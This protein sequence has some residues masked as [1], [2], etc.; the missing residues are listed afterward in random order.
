MT[1][2]TLLAVA[3]FALR[4]AVA[5]PPDPQQLKDE[6]PLA[7]SGPHRVYYLYNNCP[8]NINLIESGVFSGEVI[9]SRNFTTRSTTSDGWRGPFYT[10]ANGGNVDGSGS[11][12]AL[13][14]NNVWPH[15]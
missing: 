3:T 9:P 10:D 1:F 14:W 15:F 11:A 4:L 13:F 8:A 6:Q 2:R 7:A 5:S 12:K